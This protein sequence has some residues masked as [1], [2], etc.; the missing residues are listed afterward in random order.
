MEG[1]EP[2]P[3]EPQS[4]ALTVTLHSPCHTMERAGRIELPA[5]AWKAEVLPLYDARTGADGETRTHNLLITNQLHFQLCYVGFMR[6]DGFEP[7]ITSSGGSR[8]VRLA[9]VPLFLVW[10]AGFEPAISCSQGTRDRPNFTT[11]RWSGWRESN[12]HV[13]H[14]KE[15]C[16]RYIT[17]AWW[18]RG[19]LNS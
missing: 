9:T 4:D 5:S 8:L 18:R 11:P 17:S 12:P 19:D 6:Q 15:I 16:C 7:S 13:L 3:S 1:L 2:S 10:V 14:G